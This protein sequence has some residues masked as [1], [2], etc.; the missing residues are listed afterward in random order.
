[1]AVLGFEP[2]VPGVWRLRTVFVNVYAVESEDGWTL[3]D[4]GPPSF[5]PW[6]ALAAMQLFHDVLPKAIVLTHAHFDHSGNAKT[7][8]EEWNVPVY[9]HEQELPYVTG[10]SDYAPGDPTPGGAMSFLSRF[11]PRKGIDLGDR[12]QTFGANGEV[13]SMPGWR[14]IHTPGHTQGH[15]SFFRESDSTLVSG[16]AFTTTDT[17]SWID[18]LTWSKK[19]SRAPTPFT[20]DWQSAR[21][22]VDLL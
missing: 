8:A 3:V 9:V 2:V 13:P 14:A 16:D 17:D 5:A 22:S 10:R 12:V 15:V 21:M 20:P 19:L 1:M 11:F 6:V 7:L 4:T 18:I